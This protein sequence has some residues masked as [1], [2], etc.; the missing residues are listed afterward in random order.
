[1]TAIGRLWFSAILGLC[2]PVW[3]AGQIPPPPEPEPESIEAPPWVPQETAVF[4]E[5]R[6][7]ASFFCANKQTTRIDEADFQEFLRRYDENSLRLRLAPSFRPQAGTLNLVYPEGQE[8][9]ADVILLLAV[10]ASGA[11]REARVLCSTSTQFHDAALQAVKGARF[12]RPDDQAP[13]E[14]GFFKIK[15]RLPD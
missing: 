1:M 3:A 2:G 13:T 5:G 6:Y 8:Q 4:R 12:T 10:D 9:S 15:Y 11:V 7:R 14:V